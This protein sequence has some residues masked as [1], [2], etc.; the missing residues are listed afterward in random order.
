MP[1]PLPGPP[2][3]GAPMPSLL[4]V[5][6][7]GEEGPSTGPG[8]GEKEA[9]EAGGAPGTPGAGRG[10]RGRRRR[11]LMGVISPRQRRGLR[12]GAAGA[13]QHGAR[14]W[15]HERREFDEPARASARIAVVQERG[16]RGRVRFHAGLRAASP[17]RTSFARSTS[18]PMLRRSITP[19]SVRA[20]PRA[21]QRRAG[22]GN[23][24]AP[25]SR[26][27]RRVTRS[28][29]REAAPRGREGTRIIG[30]R[31]PEVQHRFRRG[32]GAARAAVR[33]RGGG[34]AVPCAALHARG[35]GFQVVSGAPAR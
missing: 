12:G 15:G 17:G 6:A 19:S 22:H 3:G 13:T 24:A 20:H 35:R 18:M 23:G 11:V 8:G 31:G 29:T 4:L 1:P 9:L 28:G 14:L 2:I 21:R 26:E 16:E 33:A 5:Y 34:R 32:P 30:G 7:G 10:P 27:E 25:T